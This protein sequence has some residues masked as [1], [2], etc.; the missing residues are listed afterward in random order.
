MKNRFVLLLLALLGFSGCKKESPDAYGCP[1]STYKIGGRVTDTAG[2]PIANIF[3]QRYR[4]DGGTRTDAEGAYL[5]TGQDHWSVDSLFFADTDGPENG[6]RFARKAVKI[7]R[8]KAVQT[9][10]GD[11]HWYE[12][13]YSLTIDAALEK[14]P[15]D[16][17]SL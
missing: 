5:L 12:G 9:G 8:G 15:D 11:G 16:E 2:N 1:Y 4:N 17:E 3:V 13:E 7:E 6:G 10:Q 14:Q